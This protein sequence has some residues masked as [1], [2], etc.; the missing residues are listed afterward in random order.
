MGLLGGIGREGA[1]FV[2]GTAHGDVRYLDGQYARWD[3]LRD[4]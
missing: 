2:N 1:R 4:W 3:L